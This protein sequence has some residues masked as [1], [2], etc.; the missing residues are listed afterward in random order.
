MP[1]ANELKIA[2]EK[3]KAEEAKLKRLQEQSKLLE[4]K[5]LAEEARLKILQE[6]S[7]IL[8]LKRLEDQARRLRSQVDDDHEVDDVD[9]EQ[10]LRAIISPLPSR[11]GLGQRKSDPQSEGSS[12]GGSAESDITDGG[13]MSPFPSVCADASLRRK[14]LTVND[15]LVR[16]RGN[17]SRWMATSTEEDIMQLPPAFHAIRKQNF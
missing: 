5:R 9:E 17:K 12:I 11:S 13:V 6:E 4:E 10:N 3:R 15:R 2:R 8:K 7:R 16:P 14:S 1:E